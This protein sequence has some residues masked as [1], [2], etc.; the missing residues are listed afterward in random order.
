M[1]A[2][3][4]YVLPIAALTA[5]IAPEANAQGIELRFG[6]KTKH[7]GFGLTYSTGRPACAPAPCPPP[8]VWVPGHFETR[9]QQVFVPGASQQVWVPP[10][11]E[12]R[13][14]SCGRAY[15][16]C[17]QAGFWRTVCSPGRYETREVQVW[18]DGHW[19]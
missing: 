1:N 5:L 17:V 9:C 4:K 14:D 19:N 11:Y 8:R 12:W 18:V 6:K 10:V 15:Q 13:Y 16:V 7:G 2:F 3:A